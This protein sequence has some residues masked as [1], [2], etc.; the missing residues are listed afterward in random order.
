MCDCCEEYGKKL[1]DYPRGTQIAVW[2]IYG[3]ACFLLFFFLWYVH[4]QTHRS[5]NPGAWHPPN[6]EEPTNPTQPP[7]IE[8]LS[9]AHLV[10]HRVIG[11]NDEE[12]AIVIREVVV[13]AGLIGITLDGCE[14]AT[15]STA[16]PLDGIVSPGDFVVAVNDTSVNES[17]MNWIVSVN[18]QRTIRF[19]HGGSPRGEETS[20]DDSSASSGAATSN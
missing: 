4:R 10:S 18:Q 13:T 2:S 5:M 17:N 14:I 8:E 19:V 9:Y 7:N 12:D 20:V 6:I 3:L 16:S 15:V 1:S 11:R